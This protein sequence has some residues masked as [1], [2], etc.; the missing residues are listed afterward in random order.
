MVRRKYHQDNIC[1]AVG[2]DEFTGYFI[3]V[4][5]KRLEV[6]DET[7]DDFDSV[8]LVPP[9]TGQAVIS[10][11]ILEVMGLENALA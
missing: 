2:H 11:L 9:W 6:N 4:Y 7:N 1:I 3:S 8:C 10:T 5:D